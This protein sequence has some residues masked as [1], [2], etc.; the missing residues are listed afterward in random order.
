MAWRVEFGGHSRRYGFAC[1]ARTAGRKYGMNLAKYMRRGVFDYAEVG[2]YLERVRKMM[3][4]AGWG[5]NIFW[6]RNGDLYPALLEGQDGVLGWGR[7]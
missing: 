2:R 6:L 1:E 4:I 5:S 7:R 3:W